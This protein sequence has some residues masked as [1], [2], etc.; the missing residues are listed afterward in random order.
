MPGVIFVALVVTAYWLVEGVVLFATGVSCV[1]PLY[2]SIFV[3]EFAKLLTIPVFD[4][5]KVC[6]SLVSIAVY[7]GAPSVPWLPCCSEVSVIVSNASSVWFPSATPTLIVCGVVLIVEGTLKLIVSVVVFEPFAVNVPSS[8]IPSPVNLKNGVL[9]FWAVAVNL[10]VPL[11]LG[12]A[13][14]ESYTIE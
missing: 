6:A 10:I 8:L 12:F 9:K 7:A 3:P 4:A 13:P 1:A 5:G 2:T 14:L 11:G